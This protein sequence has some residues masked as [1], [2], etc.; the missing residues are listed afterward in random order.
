MIMKAVTTGSEPEDERTDRSA[1][2]M[3]LA[4]VEAECRRLGVTEAALHA[5]QA[6]MLLASPTT[7]AAP[8]RRA[9]SVI[10]RPYLALH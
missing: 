4:Y 8:S 7:A 1:V 10:T 6:A 9:R 5:A 2:L 3:M